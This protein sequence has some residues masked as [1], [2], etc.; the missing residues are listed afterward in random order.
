[1]CVGVNPDAMLSRVKDMFANISNR[2]ATTT[3]PP[4]AADP[5]PAAAAAAAPASTLAS[6]IDYA[7]VDMVLLRVLMLCGWISMLSI[8]GSLPGGGLPPQQRATR[9]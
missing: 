6:R 5:D 3:Y 9:G 1:M 4:R 2:C 8:T 7:K